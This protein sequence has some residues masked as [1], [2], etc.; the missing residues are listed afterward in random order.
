MTPESFENKYTPEPNTGCW[1]WTDALGGKGYGKH[2]KAY[3]LYN[4]P[5]PAALQVRHTC[6]N[7]WCV[8]PA[9]LKIGTQRDNEADKRARGR[10]P[11]KLSAQVRAD[12]VKEYV[13]G[14]SNQYEMAS[15][16][17]VSQITISRIVSK[18]NQRGHKR[19]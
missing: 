17:G 2:R 5:V 1:I 12:I 14:V 8:N 6:D 7:K 18:N 11:Y 4:G 3:K 16:Y 19:G 13:P 10:Q 15:R 9:H